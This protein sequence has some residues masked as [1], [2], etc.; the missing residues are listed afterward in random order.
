MSDE[1]DNQDDG[2]VVDFFLASLNQMVKQATKQT[3]KTS[4]TAGNRSTMTRQQKIDEALRSH[5][6]MGGAAE[7][8]RTS[9]KKKDPTSKRDKERSESEEE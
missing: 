9:K 4:N 1:K 5:G 3:S 2:K 6:S 7:K 8:R